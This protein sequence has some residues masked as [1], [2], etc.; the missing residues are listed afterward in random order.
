MFARDAIRIWHNTAGLLTNRPTEQRFGHD[1]ELS[2]SHSS[3]K[4]TFSAS[5]TAYINLLNQP[6]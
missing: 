2:L 4:T 5:T 3:N 1:K 6:S